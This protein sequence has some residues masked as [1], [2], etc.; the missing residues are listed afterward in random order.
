M[1]PRPRPLLRAPRRCRR[2]RTGPV[3]ASS[4]DELDPHR[5][6]LATARRDRVALISAATEHL[7]G[8]IDAAVERANS[9][10]LFN[11]MQSPAIVRSSNHV[12]DDVHELHKVLGIES[13]REE[14]E[15]R[16]W[17]EAAE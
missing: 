10:V 17:K 14:S 5:L 3:L 11:P 13:G 9:K 7:L 1:A 12:A 4:P 2:A 8:R 16:R 15:P 6:G